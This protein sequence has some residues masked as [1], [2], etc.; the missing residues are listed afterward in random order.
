MSLRRSAPVYFV[1]GLFAFGNASRNPRFASF[2]AVDVVQ[3]L[4]SG[5]CFGLALALLITRFRT[6]AVKTDG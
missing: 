4:V 3:L 5:I 1:L 2:H 6:N